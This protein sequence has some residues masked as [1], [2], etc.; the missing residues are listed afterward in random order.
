[1]RFEVLWPVESAV[2]PEELIERM[3][4]SSECRKEMNAISVEDSSWRQHHGIAIV[5]SDNDLV[6]QRGWGLSRR[7]IRELHERG[8]CGEIVIDGLDE[9]QYIPRL[10][11]TLHDLRKKLDE[12]SKPEALG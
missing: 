7:I 1:M 2:V 3:F 5:P 4:G 12:L 9:E 8:V 6:C 10:W 11:R